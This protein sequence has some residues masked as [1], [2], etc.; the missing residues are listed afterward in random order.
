MKKP[1]LKL[2]QVKFGK[3]LASAIAIMLPMTMQAATVF[4]Y[5]NQGGE[6]YVVNVG[7]SVVGAT[8]GFY[9]LGK[10]QFVILDHQKKTFS[11]IGRQELRSLMSASKQV[12]SQ[13][14]GMSAYLPPEYRD[15][16][17]QASK[18]QASA[19]QFSLKKIG[20]QKVNGYHC[21]QYRLLEHNVVK[22]KAC[23]AS[24]E[25]LSLPKAD[26]QGFSKATQATRALLAEIPG[27]SNEHQQQLALLKEGIPLSM[28]SPNGHNWVLESVTM[29]VPEL[30]V[31]SEYAN[32]AFAMPS[33]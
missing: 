27:M 22:G 18:Q 4:K 17:G 15:A 3:V 16:L 29:D 8:D 30:Q 20:S 23:L 25:Q 6:H 10:D 21:T 13:L 9:D 31:P 24:P 1:S 33:L 32:K 11:E 28:S 26:F 12:M 7:S 19:D 2:N 14:E 5:K